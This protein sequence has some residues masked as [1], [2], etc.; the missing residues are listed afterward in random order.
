MIPV[1]AKGESPEE[2]KKRLEE[3][4]K[5]YWDFLKPFKKKKK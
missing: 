4:K 2:Y 5:N 1:P 3:F